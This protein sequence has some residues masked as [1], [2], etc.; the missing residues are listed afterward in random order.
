VTNADARSYAELADIVRQEANGDANKF[1]HLALDLTDQIRSTA[2]KLQAIAERQCNGYKTWDHK[3]DQEACDRDM[4]AETR[5]QNRLEALGKDYGLSFIFG[6]DPRGCVVRLRTPKTGKHN[7]W[8]GSEEG[9][10]VL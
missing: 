6:G 7:T 9:W 5:F 1:F 8:G 3:W 4:R 2:Q 10:A